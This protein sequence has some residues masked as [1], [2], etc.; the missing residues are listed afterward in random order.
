MYHI[1]FIVVVCNQAESIWKLIFQTCEFLRILLLYLHWAILKKI[2]GK[3][4]IVKIVAAMKLR[5]SCTKPEAVVHV[6]FC[7]FVKHFYFTVKVLL[8]FD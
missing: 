8:Y 2:S 4:D 7:W 1:S 6:K 3:I 5:I